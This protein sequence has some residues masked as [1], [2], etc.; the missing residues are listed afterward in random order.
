MK[1]TV[2]LSLL[3][4][5][6]VYAAELTSYQEAVDAVNNGK[7]LTY[8]MDWD[9]CQT[10]VPDVKPNLSSSYSPASVNIYKDSYIGARGVS[11]SHEVKVL[12]QLGS[13]NQAYE[14]RF[15]KNNVLHVINHFLDPVTYKAKMPAMEAT[16]QLGDGFKVYA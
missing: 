8:V 4:V 14:Y 3:L 11:Y 13:V 10:N 1:K 2:L 15:D 7:H 12:P 5:N 6:T 16:C 9:R